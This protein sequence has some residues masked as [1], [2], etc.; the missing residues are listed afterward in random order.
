M[1]LASLLLGLAVAP[2][3]AQ[4]A[5]PAPPAVVVTCAEFLA[6]PWPAS[7]VARRAL[8]KELE[9]ARARCIGHAGFLAALGA[10]L[11]EGGDAAQALLWLER[12]LLIEPELLGA[13]ADHALALAA[14]GEP[15]ARDALA[16]Q[17]QSRPDVPRA[18]RERLALAVAANGDGAAARDPSVRRW[19]VRRE[20][21]LLLGHES[22][23][24]HSPRLNELTLTLPEGNL[25]LP[26][27]T[28]LQPRRAAAALAD[29]SL[30][31]A[32]S[33]QPGRIWRA[34][35][36]ASARAAP[37]AADSNWQQAQLAA[38]VAERWGPWRGQAE[39]GANW[40]AGGLNEPYRLVRLTLAAER[41]TLGCNQRAAL[42]IESRHQ[43]LT[44]SADSRTEGLL[45]AAL[46]PWS[47]SPGWA[48]GLA[49]RF[50]IDHPRLDD[51]PGG[52]Q[53]LGSVGA[54][55]LGPLAGATRLD[56][57]LRVGRIHDD[58]GYS[59]LLEN[60]AARRL[61]QTLLSLELTR[62]LYL[63]NWPGVQAVVQLHAL[64]QSSNLALFAY[65]S[66]STYGGIRWQW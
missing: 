38:S 1:P 43:R 45:W 54:R 4:D 19:A 7:E 3:Q 21:S 58:Q 65:T 33:P 46:C 11:L 26:L 44:R 41:D 56:A 62:P 37:G 14:L 28:P 66:V 10:A 53:T 8:L 25:E 49:G 55:L 50:S 23:L 63:T 34:G 48:W 6:R 31:L 51:R 2:V 18:L 64:R 39:L 13:L 24:D 12:A 17:W 29:V 52:R 16:L 36:Q 59:P 9:A 27:A 5:E 20:M 42:E 57:N 15:A 30:Q 22:N 47:I 32:H 40:V 35:I 61:G 60:N